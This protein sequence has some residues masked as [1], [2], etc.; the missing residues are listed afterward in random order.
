VA[1]S[2]INWSSHHDVT[3]SWIYLENGGFVSVRLIAIVK[4]IDKKIRS[5]KRDNDNSH[6]QT[7]KEID[8]DLT[9]FG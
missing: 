8:E 3:G 6:K 4:V 2:T 9:V 1:L 5:T 7:S